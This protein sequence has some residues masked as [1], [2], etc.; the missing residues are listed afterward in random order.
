MIIVMTINIFTVSRNVA[1]VI[2]CIY[3][4]LNHFLF[5]LILARYMRIINISR[6]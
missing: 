2:I 1:E 5:S 6:G 4:N 3:S